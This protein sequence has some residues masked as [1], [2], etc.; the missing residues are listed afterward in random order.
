MKSFIMIFLGIFLHSLPGE[1]FAAKSLTP[2]IVGGQPS[3]PGLYRFTVSLRSH[4]RH[5]CGGVLIGPSTVLTA[6]HCI[7]FT[8]P[9]TVLVGTHDLINKTGGEEIKVINHLVHPLYRGNPV[10]RHDYALL[11]LERAS[12][13]EPVEMN[14][15]PL[16]EE[17]FPADVELLVAGWGLLSED[18]FATPPILQVVGV[19]V[20][21]REHCEAQY[22]NFKPLAKGY[23]DETMFCAG[24]EIGEKDA[25]QGDSGGP[26]FF[27]NPNSGT[28]TLMGLVSW[29]YGCARPGLSGVYA[30]VGWVQG[31]IQDNLIEP[32]THAE[33]Q[34]AGF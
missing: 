1:S 25:C 11:Y 7:G 21:K 18:G 33:L 6:G 32:R 4:G 19:P 9:E 10:P 28:I 23:I 8:P 3:Q 26:I 13:I 29:G 30:D 20:V 5:F 14:Q 22:Q 27:E 16:N 2:R 31:W 17:D 15:R 34:V 24:F 12:V